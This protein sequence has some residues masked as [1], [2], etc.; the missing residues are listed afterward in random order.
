MYS[1]IQNLPDSV[2]E[3]ARLDG[4]SELRIYGQIIF[5]MS[6]P[7]FTATAV[8]SAVGHWN[9]WFDVLLYNSSGSWDTLQVYLQRLLLE[10][11]ALQ[12]IQDQ[13]M[14]YNKFREVS[15]ITLRAATTIIVTFPIAVVYP[16]LQKYF[17]GGITIG[18]VKG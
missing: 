18:A 9:S 2:V 8:F 13:H 12:M 3:S 14:L 6:L 11:Q 15:P 17:V 4:C 7:V 5:P 10:V 16:F 1:Y